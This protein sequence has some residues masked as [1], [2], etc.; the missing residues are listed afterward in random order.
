MIC[1]R[2]IA[3]GELCSVNRGWWNTIGEFSWSAVKFR[4]GAIIKLYKQIV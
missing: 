2:W 4:I 1:D 3:V